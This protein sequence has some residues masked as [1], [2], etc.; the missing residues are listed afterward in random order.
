MGGPS[1]RGL[2]IQ[3]ST[4][5]YL[6]CLC[7]EYDLTTDE[8]I[9]EALPLIERRLAEFEARMAACHRDGWDEA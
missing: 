7:R 4:A 9:S 2:D 1:V 8:L 3:D 6:G 5:R